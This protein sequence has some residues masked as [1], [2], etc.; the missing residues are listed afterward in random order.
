MWAA[1]CLGAVSLPYLLTPDP[2]GYGTHE[3]FFL[4]GCLFRKLTTLPCPFC[5]L[6]TSFAY[7]V[8]GDLPDAFRC[9]PAGPVLY[10]LLAG[11][12]A[13]SLIWAVS[14]WNPLRGRLDPLNQPRAIVAIV[15]LIWIPALVVRLALH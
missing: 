5:G 9:H 6:T 10:V 11:G 4:Y 8:R 15:I 3:Q 12:A 1:V 13:Y 7:I 14:G 2:R